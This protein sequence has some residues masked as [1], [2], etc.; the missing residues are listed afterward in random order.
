MDTQIIEKLITMGSEQQ[1]P[2][3]AKQ[4]RDLVKGH[5]GPQLSMVYAM[6]EWANVIGLTLGLGVDYNPKKIEDTP[7]HNDYLIYC[8]ML[9]KNMKWLNMLHSNLDSH[10]VE[11]AGTALWASESLRLN[12]TVFKEAWDKIPLCRVQIAYRRKSNENVQEKKQ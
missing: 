4:F 11:T 8:W 6:L 7:A 12:S 9:T 3:T 1:G 2:V 10:N 5:N